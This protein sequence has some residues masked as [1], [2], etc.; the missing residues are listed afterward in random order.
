MRMHSRCSRMVP[1]IDLQ[2]PPRYRIFRIYLRHAAG[3]TVDFD[4]DNFDLVHALPRVH[5][6]LASPDSV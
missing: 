1:C 6:A 4:A 3:A 2:C 5:E